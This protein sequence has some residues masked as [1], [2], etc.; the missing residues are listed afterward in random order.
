MSHAVC[1][2]C[3]KSFESRIS[4]TAHIRSCKNN[5]MIDMENKKDDKIITG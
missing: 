3:K 2:H 5:T 4:L 1:K